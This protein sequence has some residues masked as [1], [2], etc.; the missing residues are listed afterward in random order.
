MNTGDM[1]HSTDDLLRIIRQDCPTATRRMIEYWATV[2]K[3][4]QPSIQQ[5]HGPGTRQRWSDFDLFRLSAIFAFRDELHKVMGKDTLIG[6]ECVKD[7]WDT[8]GR[9]EPWSFG[10]H[11]EPVIKA[12]V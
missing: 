4:I 1:G 5:A 7:I 12:K 2:H 9:G 6:I 8:L 10:F 11:I 3:V